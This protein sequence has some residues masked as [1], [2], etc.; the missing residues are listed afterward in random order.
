MNSSNYR[1]EFMM[2]VHEILCFLL[3]LR[4]IALHATV[5]F[6]LTERELIRS[7]DYR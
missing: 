1:S 4:L 2:L 5:Y 7:N 6:Y 3:F